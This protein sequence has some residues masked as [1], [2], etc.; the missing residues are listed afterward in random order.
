MGSPVEVMEA[1]VEPG[2]KGEAEVV[3]RMHIRYGMQYHFDYHT[4]QPAGVRLLV[5]EGG[6]YNAIER[7]SA[8]EVV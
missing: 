2:E 7:V 6:E 8:V 4:I 3:E 5:E 1:G